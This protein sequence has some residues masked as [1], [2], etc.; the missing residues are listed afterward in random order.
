MKINMKIMALI[1]ISLML[2][3]ATGGFLTFWQLKGSGVLARAQI[4]KLGTENIERIKEEGKR[5]EQLFRRELVIQKKEYLKS[6]VQTTMSVLERAFNDAHDPEKLKNVYKEQLQNAV[7]TAFGILESV[8]KEEDLSLVER[9]RKATELIQTLRYGPENKDY[10]WI[11]DMHPRM[12]MHP[13]K[14]QLNGKDLSENRD[15][16]GKKLFMEFV[17]VCRD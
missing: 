11:N 7:N 17:K 5:E 3:S 15:P 12:V 10:F 16:N 6:Q 1:T 13:Y 14:T 8:E 4:Y 2:I 9:Q